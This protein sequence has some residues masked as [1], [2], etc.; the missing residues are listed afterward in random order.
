LDSDPAA[1]VVDG[2]FDLGVEQPDVG[3]D[4]VAYVEEVA[5]GFQVPH[6]QHR[7]ALTDLD[8]GD[9]SGETRKNECVWLTRTAVI[10]RANPDDRETD[11]GERCAQVVG[12]CLAAGVGGRWSER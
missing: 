8:L 6:P 10:E 9:L 3:L 4:D 12:L 5:H 7:L 1:Y 11:F 2:G